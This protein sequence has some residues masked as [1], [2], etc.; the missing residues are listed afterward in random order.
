MILSGV[1][2]TKAPSM[3]TSKQS[4]SLITFDVCG[5]NAHA[6]SVQNPELNFILNVM[7]TCFLPV[8]KLFPPIPVEAVASVEAGDTEKPPK[9][10]L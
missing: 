2:F 4:A 5:H 3:S 6:N 8:E 7:P 10:A 9:A 1:A